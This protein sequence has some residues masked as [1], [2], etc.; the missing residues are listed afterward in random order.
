[1]SKH[2]VFSSSDVST[3]NDSTYWN[4]GY[5]YQQ[6]YG[7]G[8]GGSNDS[9]HGYYGYSPGYYYS[10]G[11][12]YEDEAL[13][14]DLNDMNKEIYLILS[15][16]A[17]ILNERTAEDASDIDEIDELFKEANATEHFLIQKRELLRQRFTV[18]LQTHCTEMATWRSKVINLDWKPSHGDRIYKHSTPPNKNHSHDLQII[19]RSTDKIH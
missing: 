1:M 13:E 14:K 8:Y 18:I 11:L 9:P 2:I 7:P 6:G 12:F 17:K 16:Y 10:S 15:I 4:Q 3:L 19:E 5:G